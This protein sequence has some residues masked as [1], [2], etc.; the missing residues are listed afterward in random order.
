MVCGESYIRSLTPTPPC[1]SLASK[2]PR[3]SQSGGPATLPPRILSTSPP[4][5][6][7]TGSA[8]SAPVARP[9]HP[10]CRVSREGRNRPSTITRT[11]GVPLFFPLAKNPR[12]ARNRPVKRDRRCRPLTFPA[13]RRPSGHDG[14]SVISS[15][16][17]RVSAFP[18]GREAPSP[19]DGRAQPEETCGGFDS[20]LVWARP[21][22]GSK[23]PAADDRVPNPRGPVGTVWTTLRKE[24]KEKKQIRKAVASPASPQRGSEPWTL[25]SAL[26]GR[27]TPPAKILPRAGRPRGP[28]PRT[29]RPCRPFRR[30]RPPSG[31]AWKPGRSSVRSP[32]F[33]AGFRK[34]GAFWGPRARPFSKRRRFPRFH[35]GVLCLAG[36]ARLSFG[37]QVPHGS[38]GTRGSP[39]LPFPLDP[40]PRKLNEIR[41]ER[42]LRHAF[43][44]HAPAPPWGARK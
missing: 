38:A 20:P 33:F 14:F 8:P 27:S 24:K 40:H 41:C 26:H 32:G 12:P 23:N 44:I 43:S 31:P 18:C 6:E 16:P 11:R 21:K 37:G 10:R 4:V 5:A 42:A 22:S 13:L 36:R 7:T 2:T 35:P 28:V 17:R 29:E 15:S 25:R 30:P 1:S 39:S 34:P 19:S 9:N 3:A